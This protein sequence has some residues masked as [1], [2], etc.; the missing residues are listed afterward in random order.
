MIARLFLLL[1]LMALA[2]ITGVRAEQLTMALSAAAVDI[3]ASFTGTQLTVFGV[4]ER[5]DPLAEIPLDAD[6][7][8]AVLLLGPRYSVVVREKKRVL[9]IWMNR[10][11]QTIINPPSVYLLS[12]SV[13]LPQL[14]SLSVLETLQIGFDNVAFVYEGLGTVNDPAAGEFHDA[15]LRLKQEDGLY[16]QQIGVGFIGNFVFSSTVRL[17]A[18]VPVGDYTAVAYLFSG[19][20]LV[21]RA[22]ERL[23]ISKTGFEATLASFARTQSLAY[24][25]MIVALALAVGW[26][27]GVIFRRD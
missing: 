25:F 19:G 6:Y 8:V 1:L 5:D 14:A 16:A 4:I 2:G 24:G 13:D 15:F 10:E 3:S 9:G 18:N 26:L 12:T 7:Q 27:G 20:G 11:S 23:V 17:P 21:A 22:E